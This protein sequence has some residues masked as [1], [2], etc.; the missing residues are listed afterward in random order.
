VELRNLIRYKDTLEQTKTQVLCRLHAQQHSA[1]PS[2]LV[3]SGLKEQITA[4]KK[5]IASM[6]QLIE[7][8][9]QKQESFN[10]QVRKIADSI[11]GV[12]IATVAA[13]A[14]ETNGFELFYSQAQ[15]TSYAG[16]DV[17]ENQS[18]NR[19]GRTRI[20]K[21]GNSHIRKTLHFPALNVV[22]LEVKTFS[23]L[24]ERVYDRTRIKMK[25]YVAVQRKLLCMIY[26]LWKK[27]EAFDPNYQEKQEQVQD[28]GQSSGERHPDQIAAGQ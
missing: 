17:I 19:K 12:G 27:N 26:T 21:K 22:R 18:G 4:L 11:N 2:Q 14:A 13:I 8:L 15:L 3:I 7:E 23:N 25:G 28:S 9:L 6:N 1:L 5:R 20:S 24:Y 16:Y 10:E